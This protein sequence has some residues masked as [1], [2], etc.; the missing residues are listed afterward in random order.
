MQI[1]LKSFHC[2]VFSLCL[3]ALFSY[4]VHRLTVF[5]FCFLKMTVLLQ[6]IN[7]SSYIHVKSSVCSSFLVYIDYSI[8]STDLISWNRASLKHLTQ[9]HFPSFLL[10]TNLL[11]K[12][13]AYRSFWHVAQNWCLWTDIC[14]VVY[15]VVGV[16]FS[17]SS[18]LMPTL[19]VT[20][21]LLTLQLLC[22]NL[23]PMIL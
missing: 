4:Y 9:L 15:W 3:H 18:C 7:L 19:P 6:S 21:L 17:G 1:W 20:W 23:L 5:Y 16:F 14:T 8:E 22:K 2:S 10:A 12:C 13:T 11:E